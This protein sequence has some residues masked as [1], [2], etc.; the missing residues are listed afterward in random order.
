MNV[1]NPLQT[2]GKIPKGNSFGPPGSEFCSLSLWL[3][4]ASH[5]RSFCHAP[6]RPRGQSGPPVGP[7]VSAGHSGAAPVRA[8]HLP[9]VRR[10]VE[11]ALAWPQSNELKAEYEALYANGW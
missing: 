6:H 1:C 8:A 10:A 7:S 4:Q 9:G 5:T 11:E 3:I 2:V